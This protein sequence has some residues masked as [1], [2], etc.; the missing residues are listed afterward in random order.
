MRVEPDLGK[1][2]EG[3]DF[4]RRSILSDDPE[5]HLGDLVNRHQEHILKKKRLIHSPPRTVI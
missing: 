2:V 5:I 1:H 4:L 3:S